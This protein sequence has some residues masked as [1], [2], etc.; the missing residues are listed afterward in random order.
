MNG[1]LRL[2][3]MGFKEEAG[4]YDAIAAGFQGKRQWTDGKLNG[5]V[6]ETLLNTSFD[7]DG[8]RQPQVFATE[9]D[10]QRDSD[11]ARQPPHSASSV[12]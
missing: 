8:L 11:A 9:G 3:D 12:L 2:A 5:D 7:S 10:A 1:N 6:M 4:G